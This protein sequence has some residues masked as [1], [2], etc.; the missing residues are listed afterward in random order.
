MTDLQTA[1]NAARERWRTH[2][3]YSG[4]H[5]SNCGEYVG[6]RWGEYPEYGS[7]GCFWGDARVIR[8]PLA[9]AKS[10]NV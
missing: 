5:C 2:W 10:R 6:P 8:V 9:S 1:I 4:E 7:H 3:S